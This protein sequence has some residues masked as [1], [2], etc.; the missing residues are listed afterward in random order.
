MGDFTKLTVTEEETWWSLK[1]ALQEIGMLQLPC[2]PVR[3]PNRKEADFYHHIVILRLYK[4]GP[5]LDYPASHQNSDFEL[6]NLALPLAQAAG[7]RAGYLL[8][9]SLQN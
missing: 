9:F 2:N 6:Y 5:Y 4:W 7:I 1:T 8:F 3:L